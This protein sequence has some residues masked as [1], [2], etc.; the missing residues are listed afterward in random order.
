MTNK[1]DMFMQFYPNAVS[2]MTKHDGVVTSYAI[3]DYWDEPKK[4]GAGDFCDFII[5]LFSYANMNAPNTIKKFFDHRDIKLDYDVN[6]PTYCLYVLG[7]GVFNGVHYRVRATSEH[8]Y[9]DNQY[10]LDIV[11]D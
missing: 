7:K 9:H 2:E 11:E 1:T 5:A 6:N 8:K 10:V 4:E 3:S